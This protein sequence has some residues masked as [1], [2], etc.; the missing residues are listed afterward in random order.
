MTKPTPDT[1][2]PEYEALAFFEG[3][4]TVAELPP[5]REFRETCAWLPGGRRHM[6]CRSR[7]R[8]ATGAL[9]EG[10]SLFSYDPETGTYLYYGLRPSGAVETNRGTFDGERWILMGEDRDGETIRRRRVTIRK[11]ESGGYHFMEE[12]TD[13]DDSWRVVETCRYLPASPEG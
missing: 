3:T 5:E 2:L 10:L 9:R 7:L 8:T 12:T 1:P 13:G 6:V 11:A 4:W